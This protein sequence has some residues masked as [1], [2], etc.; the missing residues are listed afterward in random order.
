MCYL[1]S[2]I[3]PYE[4]ELFSFPVQKAN[5]KAKAICPVS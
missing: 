4:V 2:L 3:L 5:K 1:N